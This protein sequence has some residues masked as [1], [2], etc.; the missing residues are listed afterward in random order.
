[1]SRAKQVLTAT[2][3]VCVL[4]AVLL[5]ATAFYLFWLSAAAA[6]DVEMYRG[7]LCLGFTLLLCIF[8]TALTIAAAESR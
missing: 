7:L 4:S 1:M 8:A 6:G 2:A 5:A 3:A